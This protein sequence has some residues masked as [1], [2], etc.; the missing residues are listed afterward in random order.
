M[1]GYVGIKDGGDLID[2]K[3]WQVYCFYPT[4]LKNEM[5]MERVMY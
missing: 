4:I 2:Y 5:K 1:Y 3:L